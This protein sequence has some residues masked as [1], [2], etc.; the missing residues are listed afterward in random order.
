MVIKKI[1]LIV[2]F[3]LL[4]SFI[5]AEV[6]HDADM[7]GIGSDVDNC[8]LD[9]NPLQE[10]MDYDGIGNICDTTPEIVVIGPIINITNN[11]VPDDNSSK[12]ICMN[13]LTIEFICEPNWECGGWSECSENGIKVRTCEDTNNC[14]LDYGKPIEMT[15]CEMQKSLVVKKDNYFLKIMVEISLILILILIILLIINKR[16]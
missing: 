15:N 7:D 2:T 8:P 12:K 3:L 10:D 6:I 16:K 11:T 14:S 5:Q 1:I 4:I 9:Y 13:P